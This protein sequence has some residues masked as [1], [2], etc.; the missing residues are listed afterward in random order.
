[1]NNK[2]KQD[3]NL[4][5]VAQQQFDRALTWVDDLKAGL[6]ESLKNPRRVTHVYFPVYMDD[7][8]VRMFHGFRVLHN[9]ARDQVK[10]VFDITLQFPRTK[11]LHSLLS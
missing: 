9:N 8:S 4:F 7:E 3:V 5:D 11:S 10:G 2:I 1:M 6:I